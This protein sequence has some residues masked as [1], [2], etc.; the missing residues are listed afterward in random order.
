M[1]K[2]SEIMLDWGANRYNIESL[3][4]MDYIFPP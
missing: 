3:S 1:S 2:N 4:V